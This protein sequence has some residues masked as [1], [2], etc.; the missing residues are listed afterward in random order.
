M[1]H[2][3]GVLCHEAFLTGNENISGGRGAHAHVDG[4]D[5]RSGSINQINEA[6]FH[7]ERT[8]IVKQID[9]DRLALR[10]R[11]A[12]IFHVP[13]QDL[14]LPFQRVIV[15][16]NIKPDTAILGE[17]IKIDDCQIR[18]LGIKRV[19]QHIKEGVTDFSFF[20]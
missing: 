20:S 2:G 16:R 8:A 15:Y 12:T 3:A 11:D 10:G 1:Q 9:P 17:F 6:P 14:L 13:E 4:V 7:I 18:Q 5:R 19:V